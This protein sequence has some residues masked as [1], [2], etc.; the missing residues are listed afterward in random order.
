[1]QGKTSPIS[2][3]VALYNNN[4]NNNNNNNDAKEP[5]AEQLT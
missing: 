4:N 2:C 1:M 3:C 5:L